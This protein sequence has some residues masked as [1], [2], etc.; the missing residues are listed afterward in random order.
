[1]DTV[2]C[3]KKVDSYLASDSFRQP[4]FICVNSRENL[5]QLKKCLPPKL[6]ELSVADFCYKPDENPSIDGLL[7]QL[8]IDNRKILLFDL[9]PALELLGK[10]ELKKTLSTLLSLPIRG[11]LIVFCFQG[12]RYFKELK[13]P[14]I[15]RRLIQV[16][17]K[18]DKNP[19]IIFWSGDVAITQMLP[20][21]NSIKELIPKIENTSDERIFVITK[22]K[23][24]DYPDSLLSIAEWTSAYD[25]LIKREPEIASVL[26]ERLG[27]QAQWKELLQ[28]IIA[29]KSWQDMIRAEFGADASPTLLIRQWKMWNDFQQWLCFISLKI[30]QKKEQGYLFRT[31]LNVSSVDGMIRGVYRELLSF[32]P[33]SDDFPTEYRERKQLLELFGNPDS[34]VADF[35]LFVDSKEKDAIY[36]LTNNT[37]LEK[38]K[39]IA[40]LDKYTYS[41]DELTNILQFVYPEISEYLTSY[42]FDIPLFDSYFQQYKLQKI[43]NR[44][45]PEFEDVVNQQAITR[46]YNHLVP[47]RCSITED[48]IGQ[49][50]CAYWIDAFGVE[51]LGYLMNRC[52]CFGLMTDIKICRANIPTITSLNK[53]FVEELDSAGIDLTQI[54]E[55]DEIK[56]LGKDNFDYEKTKLPLYLI[57]ELEI[58]DEVIKSVSQRLKSGKHKRAAIF[59]DHGASRLAVIKENTMNF[60]VDA[61]GTHGGRCCVYNESL[62]K[63]ETATVEDGYYVLAGYDRFK[64]GRKASVETHGGATLEEVLVPVVVLS[65]RASDIEVHFLGTEITVSF[66]KK[67]CIRLFSK[68][69]LSSVSMRINQTFYKALNC[70]NIWTFE[71]QDLRRPG[72]YY[73]D[74]YE[75]GNLIAEQLPFEIVSEIARKND[76]L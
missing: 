7:H 8:A 5:R 36:Y 18:M 29:Q 41:L 40:C 9:I 67:A 50:D 11:K 27:S 66:R 62:P 32:S 73:A 13:D 17:G 35:C 43:T 59:S 4:L 2:E 37:Q 61:K 22:K 3:L 44:I 55:L 20:Q 25:I 65:L 71:M 74:I 19:L 42:Y 28:K 70:D 75:N 1:M 34:E 48:V 24:S 64:G 26:D 54:K 49:V 51:F 69:K 30:N 56:H 10:I 33:D 76:L 57:R 15:E 68:T 14:R 47:S 58:I 53:E 46:D 16:D 60:E 45:L 38:E 12:M 6:T 52:R 21:A 39:I 31:A 72:K 23:K 63:I